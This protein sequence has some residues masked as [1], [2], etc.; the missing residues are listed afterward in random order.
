MFKIKF[1]Q[2]QA[3]EFELWDA[4]VEAV[5]PRQSY[6]GRQAICTFIHSI[7]SFNIFQGFLAKVFF[8][9]SVKIRNKSFTLGNLGHRLSLALARLLMNMGKDHNRWHFL[10]S[11]HLFDFFVL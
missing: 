10:F 1:T 9:D 3:T 2:V 8:D 7:F 5:L 4:D 6:Y 11:D